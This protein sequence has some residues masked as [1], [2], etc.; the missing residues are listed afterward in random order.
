M[1]ASVRYVRFIVR[2][3]HNF[4]SLHECTEL[5]PCVPFAVPR[6]H[7]CPFGDQQFD[8]VNAVQSPIF[9]R[10]SPITFSRKLHDIRAYFSRF[11]KCKRHSPKFDS[12]LCQR[13]RRYASI[14]IT[15]LCLCEHCFVDRAWC[16]H[17]HLVLWVSTPP[18]RS[19]SERSPCK[20][21]RFRMVIFYASPGCLFTCVQ[22]MAAAARH[23]SWMGYIHWFKITGNCLCGSLPINDHGMK[24]FSSWFSDFHGNSG[25]F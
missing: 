18:P 10:S 13:H 9:I 17:P 6:T 15:L 2:L 21:D 7:T 14:E 4:S 24:K 23:L 3:W 19:S 16:P 8:D 22:Q 1:A 12:M 20:I 25:H 5:C 11:K